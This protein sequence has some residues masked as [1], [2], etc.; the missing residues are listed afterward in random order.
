M[1]HAVYLLT[2]RFSEPQSGQDA[3]V[4]LTDLSGLDPRDDPVVL[5]PSG[6]ILVALVADE[7]LDEARLVIARRGGDVLY[8]ERREPREWRRQRADGT[9][10]MARTPPGKRRH[11]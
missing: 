6:T 2:A 7:H 10:R 5:S 8:E 3:A 9:G 4:E 11:P 1:S